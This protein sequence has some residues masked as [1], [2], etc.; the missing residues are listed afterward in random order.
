MKASR[1]LA[2][3]ILVS[4]CGGS[5]TPPAPTTPVGGSETITGRERIGWDQ[6]A[7]DTAQLATFGWAVY[8]DS[9]RSIV[10]D[11]SCSGASAGLFLCS[12]RMPSLSAGS[13]TLAVATF[14]ADDPTVESTR[15]APL[16]VV[17]TASVPGAPS[18]EWQ[19]GTIE[20]SADGVRL[21]LDRLAGGLRDPTDAAFAPDGRLFI[22]ERP[23]RIA[24]FAVGVD[25]ATTTM[26]DGRDG[27]DESEL[28][29]LALDPGFERTNLV[30]V[31]STAQRD[32]RSFFRLARYR[33]VRGTLGERA[34]LLDGIP[35]PVDRRSAV[36]R[37][38]PDGMLYLALDAG[39]DAGTAVDPASFNGKLLRL[40]PDGTTPRDQA[41]ATPIVLNGLHAPRGLAFDAAGLLWLAETLDTSTGRLSAIA[42]DGERPLR[43]GVRAAYDLKRGAAGA[44]APAAGVRVPAWQ[45]DLL[46]ASREGRFITRL[47][48][49]ASGRT[50]IAATDLLLADRVGPIS[51]AV[52]GPDGAIYFCTTDALGRLV[53]Q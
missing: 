31:V 43:P 15:S 48:R 46:M 36:L 7:G 38:G 41:S 8:V 49:A 30:F 26:I 16:Q 11:V 28:L 22:A 12:G 44:L 35:A 37:F 14:V 19:G 52:V 13:H 18:T 3:L 4:A 33:E 6:P 2:V 25:A 40:G 29:A 45:S 20:T 5:R 50:E 27:G 21:R 24:I 23:G 34:I 17:V 9:V 42:S 53:P 32:G 51:V 10:A 47:H 39:G 1:F